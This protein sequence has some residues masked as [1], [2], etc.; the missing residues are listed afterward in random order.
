MALR[1]SPAV[2]AA[3]F[4]L[5]CAGNE[6]AVRVRT[7]S[8]SVPSAQD[9]EIDHLDAY[10]FRDADALAAWCGR[11]DMEEPAVRLAGERTYRWHI[12][13]NAPATA[14]Y[15]SEADFLKG[16]TWLSHSTPDLPVMHADTVCG[17]PPDGSPLALSLSRYICKVTLR[18]I[19]VKWLESF[20]FPTECRIDTA[21]LVNVP[22]Y[23]PLSGIPGPCDSIYNRGGVEKSLPEPVK[24]L[25]IADIGTEAASAAPLALDI[26]L[27]CLPGRDA[28]TRLSLK[29][30]IDGQDNWYPVNLPPLEG[31]RNYVISELVIEG[32][33]TD[34]PDGEI[35]RKNISLQISVKPWEECTAELDFNTENTL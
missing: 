34:V 20:D 5:S 19:S 15:T 10:I 2:I 8:L 30:R 13:A 4:I 6:P 28:S 29:L 27:Y 32:P 21:V 35:D 9:A 22:A 23:V 31:N 3:I 12:V 26:P 1:F 17:I 11:L 24:H 7:A 25:V 16:R 14:V 33:G 18:D